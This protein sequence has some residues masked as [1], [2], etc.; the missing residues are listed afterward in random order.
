MKQGILC[1]FSGPP[2]SGKSTFIGGLRKKIK[3]LVIVSTDEIRYELAK[4]YQFR[5][6]FEPKVW[7]LAYQQILSHLKAGMIV[8]LD[9]TLI[10]AELRG[11]VLAKFPHFPIVYF[12]F[13]KPDFQLIQ[14]RNNRRKWK[15]ISPDVLKSMY[16]AYQ[17][18]TASERTYYYRVIDVEYETFSS[19]IE[20]GVAFLE[21]IYG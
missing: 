4:D 9:A 18:P 15:Q 13:N 5:P 11:I 21:K 16:D 20:L 17:F 19:T 14:E 1:I 7:D 10:N 3:N 8:C 6:E 2:L 12:A